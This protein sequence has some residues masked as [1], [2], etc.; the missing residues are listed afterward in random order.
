MLCYMHDGEPYGHLKVKGK[1]IDE[2]NLARMAGVNLVEAR[3]LVR[4]LEK[5][6]VFDRGPGGVIINRRMVR[7]ETVRAKRAAGGSKGGN[8]QLL[9]E[10]RE[11][12]KVNPEGATPSQPPSQPPSDSKGYPAPANAAAYVVG[13][14][15]ERGVQGGENRPPP[16]D[17]TTRCCLTVNRVL[18]EQLAGAYSSLVASVERPTARA[19]EAAGIPIELAESVLAELAARFPNGRARQPQ[20]LG[21][22]TAALHEAAAKAQAQ[23]GLR[24]LKD[25]EQM[26]RAAAELLRASEVAP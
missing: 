19:W 13:S 1:V 4:E 12:G 16:L 11:H 15:S 18:S 25:Y 23:G 14:G 6:G 3:R 26:E 17:Y 2:D 24:P 7:D 8:P 22:F 10:K 9:K 20:S 5:A 21:Y